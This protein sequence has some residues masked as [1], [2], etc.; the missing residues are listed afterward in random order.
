MSID[1]FISEVQEAGERQLIGRK[2]RKLREQRRARL[3]I[4]TTDE[5]AERLR[6][7]CK[8][9]GV[10]QNEVLNRLIADLFAAVEAGEYPAQG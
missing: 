9:N 8:S 5:T 6:H 3:N 2:S 10:S 7:W 4:A 1:E